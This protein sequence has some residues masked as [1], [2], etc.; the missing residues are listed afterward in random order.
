MVVVVL[1]LIMLQIYKRFLLPP[2]PIDERAVF[3]DEKSP[4]ALLR[5]GQPV[6]SVN[7]EKVLSE[8]QAPSQG[9]QA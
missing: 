1:L 6:T 5:P 8:A 2:N 4:A 3:I 9:A 7:I